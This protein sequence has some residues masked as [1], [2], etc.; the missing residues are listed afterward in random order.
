[1]L[2]ESHVGVI[3]HPQEGKVFFRGK[4]L[5]PRVILGCMLFSRLLE[6]VL[7]GTM[8]KSEVT[9]TAYSRISNEKLSY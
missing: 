6:E 1:M 9:W 5:L 2:G 3:S 7:K 8:D 4:G